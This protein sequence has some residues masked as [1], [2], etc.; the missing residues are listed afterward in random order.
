AQMPKIIPCQA[1]PNSLLTYTTIPPGSTV[2]RTD[3]E[4]IDPAD[5][6]V[7]RRLGCRGRRSSYTSPEPAKLE[8]Q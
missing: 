2:I 4:Y 7:Y 8:A 6:C 5:G 1:C 3:Q